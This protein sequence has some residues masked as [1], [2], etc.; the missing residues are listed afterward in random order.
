MQAFEINFDGLVGM[1]HHYAGL[2]FG[3]EASFANKAR[4]ANPRLAAKQGLLKMK[5]LH[6]LGLTQGVF[7]PHERPNIKALRAL[8]FSGKDEQVLIKASK[9]APQLLS[10]MASASAMW[11]ANAATFSPSFDTQ[12]GRAHITA[13]NLNNKLHRAIEHGTTTRLLKAMFVDDDYFCHHDALIGTPAMGDEGAA[14]HGR[15]GS[16]ESKSVELFVYGAEG[17]HDPLAPKRYPAR[18]TLEASQAIARLHGLDDDCTV[19]A[20][21]N[22]AVIDAGVFHNDV[23][24]VANESVLFCHELAFFDKRGVYQQLRE[25]M[26]RLGHDL[27]VIEVKDTDVSVDDAVKSYLFNSQLITR[28][29]G[30]MT[31]IVPSECDEVVSVREYLARLVHLDTPIDDVQSYDLRQSMQN[32]GG[33]ACLRFRALVEKEALVGINQNV[34]FSDELFATLNTWVDTHY[35]ESLSQSELVDPLL[36]EQN[37]RALDELTQILRLGSVYDFQLG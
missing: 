10:A 26:A 8:G 4:L 5:A 19:F 16:H 15:L 12:D 21:Q 34:L 13:A 37:R 6:D 24:S 33:P 11:T 32:G 35:P 14:N 23:I 3:N 18:Q 31:L 2:S 36:L 9:Q 17:F 29:D 28:P 27:C 22:P 25:K 1:T 30:G 7:A 20:R